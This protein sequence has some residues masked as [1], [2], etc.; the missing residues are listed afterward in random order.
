MQ[1]PGRYLSLFFSLSPSLRISL[2]VYVGARTALIL[3]L[4]LALIYPWSGYAFACIKPYTMR[5]YQH[6]RGLVSRSYTVWIQY[7]AIR[8]RYACIHVYRVIQQKRNACIYMY[9]YIFVLS[10]RSNGG[11][12]NREI[13][14]WFP[15]I[16]DRRR[17]MVC[18]RKIVRIIVI[19]KYIRSYTVFI[20]LLAMMNDRLLFP[21]LIWAI[22]KR[23]I[24]PIFF[25][26]KLR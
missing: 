1:R 23:D 22:D 6:G 21:L 26:L 4:I 19:L 12:F 20:Y 2:R 13:A 9:I 16:S 3:T 5:L 25:V 8:V 10:I 24:L 15:M 14:R 17:F 7:A 18:V 11:D